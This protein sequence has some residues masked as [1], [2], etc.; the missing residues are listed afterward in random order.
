MKKRKATPTEQPQN[1]QTNDNS[2][3]NQ[4]KRFLAALRQASSDG[5]TTIQS[6][7]DLDVMHPAARV[8]ELRQREGWNIQTIWTFGTNA[9]GNK[10]RQARYVLFSDDYRE[11]VR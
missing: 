2:T 9:Q 11:V 6:R 4:R 3:A 7:E 1:T 8:M 10:H 5:I